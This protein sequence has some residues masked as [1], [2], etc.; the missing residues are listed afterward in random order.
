MIE[1]SRISY[2]EL[3]TILN[4]CTHTRGIAS[5]FVEIFRNKTLETLDGQIGSARVPLDLLDSPDFY[6]VLSG[7]NIDLQINHPQSP[8]IC[9]L[10]AQ[11]KKKEALAPALSLLIDRL[12]RK[13]NVPNG[14]PSA[15]IVDEFATVRATSV[16][17]TIATGRS[18]DIT[19]II[20]LQDINQLKSK[21]S[22]AEADQVMTTSGNLICGQVTG[23]TA[24]WVKERF[25]SVIDY[26]TTISINSSD[27]SIAKGE[28]S[29]E[30]IST[31][32]LASLSSGEFVGVLADDPDT[33]LEIKTFHVRLEKDPSDSIRPTQL[34]VVTPVDNNLLEENV[35]RIRS[36]IEQL[37]AAETR[38]ITNDPA[39]K[40]FIV[41]R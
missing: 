27:T 32:T 16:L 12:N 22:H 28:Q 40:K 37:V 24:R 1:L 26:K 9:C 13:I 36:E 15:L 30:S 18:H 33:P 35:N 25:E 19:T 10:A 34:P 39:L 38:R 23:E 17:D 20:A 7:N 11:S 6:Y 4:A 2:E 14:Y 21:Y 5:K 29:K 3:F 31:A 8:A 41:K